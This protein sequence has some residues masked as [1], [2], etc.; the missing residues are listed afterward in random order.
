MN[1]K[2]YPSGNL[3][4]QLVEIAKGW[5][6]TYGYEDVTL[7]VP[8]QGIRDKQNKLVKRIYEF[9]QKSLVM[10]TSQNANTLMFTHTVSFKF[11]DQMFMN[12]GVTQTE[13]FP[14]SLIIQF[15]NEYM[16]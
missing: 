14:D 16:K 3:E 1:K 12:Q 13:K 10:T 7:G 8:L 15:I 2:E 5:K 11:G 9:T 6:K 4:E